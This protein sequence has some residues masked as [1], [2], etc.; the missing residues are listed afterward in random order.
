MGSKDPKALAEFYRRALGLNVLFEAG[1]MV[2]VDAGA[3]RLMIGQKPPEEPLGGDVILYFEPV[4]WDAAER[5]VAA[6]GAS[7]VHDAVILQ[8]AEGRELALRAFKDPEGH[9]RRCWDGA[10]SSGVCC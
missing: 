4:V 10:R 7:F 2:F 3:V 8:S 5:A 9:P 6:A 1:G